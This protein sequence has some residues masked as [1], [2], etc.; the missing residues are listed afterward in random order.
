MR[1]L[2]P[3][4]DCLTSVVSAFH[5]W[6]RR[7]RRLCPPRTAGF[8]G[9]RRCHTRLIAVYCRRRV[10]WGISR[11]CRVGRR[12]KTC[13][14]T[15]T[16]RA[17]AKYC[18]ERVCMC[19]CLCVCLSVREH[20]SRTTRAIYISFCACCLSPC[21]GHLP[22]GDTIPRGRVN[23]GSFLPHWQCI[24]QH[25]I[26]YPHKNSWTDRH[27]VLDEDSGG[28]TIPK[29]ATCTSSQK[30]NWHLVLGRLVI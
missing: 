2:A 15:S 25:S 1:K 30:L 28:P 24:V 8:D 18:N 12:T 14:I 3:E 21:F 20:I 9:P 7:P 6:V 13:I 16:A 10:L 27:A 11:R 5:A 4:G 19:V 23:F 17:V 29:L 26:W 22:G